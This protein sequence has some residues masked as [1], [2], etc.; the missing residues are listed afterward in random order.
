MYE[1]L[2]KKP[3][4]KRLTLML[5]GVLLMGICVSFLRRVHFGTDPFS[6][7]NYGLE[8]HIP[9]SFGTLELITNGLMLVIVLFFNIKRLGFGTVGNMVII[10]YMADF[11][12]FIMERFFGLGEITYLPARIGIM[13]VMVVI[14]VFSCALYMNA[15]LGASAYDALPYIITDELS[16]VLNKKVSFT[17]VRVV[18]DAFFTGIAFL[19]GGEAGIITILMVISLGPV[20]TFVAKLLSDILKLDAV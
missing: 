17:V 7:M 6:A 10:G 3:F 15:G 9:I 13:L 12:D 1:L 8:K 4:A 19:L 16:K 2:F 20:I 14:F 11:T 5:V 18:F